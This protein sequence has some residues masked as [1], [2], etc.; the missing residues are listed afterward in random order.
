MK[1]RASGILLFLPL[2]L[3]SQAGAAPAAGADDVYAMDLEQLAQLQ[4]STP[5]RTEESLQHTAGTVLVFTREDIRERGFRNLGELMQS[6]PGV[7]VQGNSSADAFNTVSWRGIAGN[8]MFIIMQNGVRINTPA[9]E[10]M[11]VS[12]NFPLYSAQRVEI[13]YGPGSALYG[14]DALS[15]VINIITDT[16]EGGNTVQAAAE[17]G[18][19]GYDRAGV[20]GHLASG[21]LRLS[22]GAQR[23]GA[24]NTDLGTAYPQSF[25]L[26]DLTDAHGNVVIPGADRNP[27][28]G[29]TASWQ[30]YADALL[31]QHW[32]F[33]YDG[34]HFLQPSTASDLPSFDNYGDSLTTDI[35]TVYGRY[36]FAPSDR[37]SGEFTAN[38]SD[39]QLSGGSAFDNQLTNYASLYKYAESQRR[40]AELVLNDSWAP[41]Q[42]LTGG[43]VLEGIQAIP[44]TADLTQPYVAGESAAAQGLYYAGTNNT[45]PVQ[46]FDVHYHDWA[47]FLQ[48]QSEWTPQVRTVAAVRYDNYSNFG[49]TTNPKLAL[50]VEPDASQKLSL[51]YG[52]AFL[53]PSPYYT[54]EL[55]GSFSGNRNAQGLYEASSM[56]VPNTALGPERVASWEL[57]HEWRPD[58]AWQL[59]STLYRNRLLGFI[60]STQTNPAIANFVPGGIIAATTINTNSGEVDINGLDIRLDHTQDFSAGHLK[61][62]ASFSY[63]DGSQDTGSGTQPIPFTPKDGAKLGASWAWGEGYSVSPSLYAASPSPTEHRGLQAP[64]YAVANIYARRDH[65]L[66]H[67]NLFARVDDLFDTA[68][69][70]AGAGGSTT[71]AASPQSR[72]TYTLGLELE[73]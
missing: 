1:L 13:V 43:A 8:N 33:G 69:Y 34:S 21:S 26:G 72:R 45:L 56:Q 60:T 47:A 50:I 54:Y 24:N 16:A 52:T 65:V 44:K 29:D 4:V 37:L 9:G 36:R 5:T 51:S 20:Q 22:A 73:L 23:M 11:A 7:Y 62:W 42:T 68:W 61:S 28:N 10:P 58:G 40:Q 55:F 30:A 31:G 3:P 71:L 67:L 49:G 6:L 15:G 12:D 18:D 27:Y 19:V 48:Q 38:Y 35:N 39:Y 32:Q 64:G 63:A 57:D 17:K 66:P 25:S 41:G 70:N 59:D 2:L 14:T 46:I 53:A